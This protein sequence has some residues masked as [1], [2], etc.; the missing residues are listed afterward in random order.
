MIVVVVGGVVMVLSFF[1][2]NTRFNFAVCAFV[3]Y[4]FSL[5]DGVY[6]I[7]NI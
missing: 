3:V 1:M 7:K 6:T 5:K 2:P 4:R